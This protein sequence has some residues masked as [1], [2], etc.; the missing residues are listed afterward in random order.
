LYGVQD[1][2][3]VREMTKR[4]LVGAIQRIYEPGCQN[5][6]VLILTG[7]QGSGKS[8]GVKSKCNNR[9]VVG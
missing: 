4:W 1:T 2:P 6:N 8:M 9:S 5:D 3:L 7:P